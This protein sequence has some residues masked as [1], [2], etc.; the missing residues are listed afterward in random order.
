M[1]KENTVTADEMAG[2]RGMPSVNPEKR[3]S[4][5]KAFAFIVVVLILFIT[6]ALAY[7][8]IIKHRRAAQEAS[9]SANKELAAPK[10]P[11]WFSLPPPPMPDD[12]KSAASAAPV[13]VVP[14]TGP[15]RPPT[16][17]GSSGSGGPGGTGKPPAKLDKSGSALM[18]VAKTSQAA[19]GPAAAG[20][21]A[22]LLLPPAGGSGG[23]SG[24]LG[25]LLKPTSTDPRSASLLRDRDYLLTKGTMIQCAL[26]T[27]LD[28]TVPGMT[29]CVV[30]QPIY[31]D[32]GKVLLVDRG[33]V[34]TGE[35]RSNMTQG[36]SR[37]FVLWDRVKTPNGVVVD[38]D[39]P[40]TDE[41]GGGGVPGFINN[42]FWK[43]FGG[44]IM[45]SLIQDTMA[46]AVANQQSGQSQSITFGNTS[47]ATDQMAAEALKST[48][49]IPPTLI[50]NQG[51][52]VGIYVARDVDFRSVYELR[53]N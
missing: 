21:A 8:T 20:A 3:G 36:M 33:S 26:L 50:K 9:S 44:A 35:Y 48:I 18:M 17:G 14:A 38:L 30:T 40:G 46:A 5:K 25:D 43:R 7:R 24:A 12:S 28:T 47:T 27:K 22:A 42:H 19:P 41:L 16:L 52:R 34:V 45:L 51:D 13:A 31:S 10:T 4:P 23:A 32:N 39:S 29:S 6:A 37:I 1:S 53:S 15:E 49:N 11:K 2:E